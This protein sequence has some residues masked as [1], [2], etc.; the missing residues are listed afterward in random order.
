MDGDGRE[1]TFT[2]QSIQFRSSTDRFDENN[3]LVEFQCVEEVV[4]LTILLGFGKTNIVL[5]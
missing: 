3:D 1:I 2:Q 5:L 4:E